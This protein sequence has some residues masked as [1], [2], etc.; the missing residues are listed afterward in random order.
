MARL[1][2]GEYTR[3]AGTR[4]AGAFTV[5]A[6]AVLPAAAQRAAFALRACCTTWYRHSVTLEAAEVNARW[7][8]APTR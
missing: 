8:V 5:V 6:A 2:H 3:L 7:E 4:V 1:H